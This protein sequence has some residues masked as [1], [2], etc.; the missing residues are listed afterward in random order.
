[1]KNQMI[2]KMNDLLDSVYHG[3][4]V[5]L[6]DKMVIDDKEFKIPYKRR[7]TIVEDISNASDGE[8]AILTITFSLVLIQL[9]L[10]KYNIMLLDEIDTSLD[11]NTRGKF[12]DLIE[13]YM[14]IIGAKQ[15]F[16]ISH[17][18][19]FDTYPI[20]VIMTSEQNISNMK[21]ANVIKLYE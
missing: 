1:M 4:L 7:N 11:Y 10:D 13:R 5:L 18:N 19:M 3:G 2:D 6:K 14:T 9:S 8:R 16:L 21:M 12:L 17:N 15:L 20:N